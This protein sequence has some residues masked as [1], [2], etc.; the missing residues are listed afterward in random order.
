[1]WKCEARNVRLCVLIRTVKEIWLLKSHCWLW[2]K[3]ET[4]LSHV[5]IITWW[6]GKLTPQQP[7]TVKATEIQ[8]SH[9]LWCIRHWRT[10]CNCIVSEPTK[11]R[12][13]SVT[14]LKSDNVG[15][16]TSDRLR[17]EL[18]SDNVSLTPFISHIHITSQLKHLDGHQPSLT[19]LRPPTSPLI[20]VCFC[21]WSSAMSRVDDEANRIVFCLDDG[22]LSVV[23]VVDAVCMT[24]YC[25]VSTRV[26][27]LLVWETED[28]F[29]RYWCS[30]HNI[31]F[32]SPSLQPSSKSHF[33]K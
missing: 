24:Q 5:L 21:R 4:I 32:H 15:I 13:H 27:V 23:N 10:D 6:S 28:I 8:T 18:M 17:S 31:Y 29:I 14:V 20:D 9:R 12:R 30:S 25:F 2:K 22:C 1:M 26:V 16:V 3:I 19:F 7:V 33:H 11:W